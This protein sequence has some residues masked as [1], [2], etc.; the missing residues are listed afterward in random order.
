MSFLHQLFS[1][2]LYHFHEQLEWNW[3]SRFQERYGCLRDEVIAALQKYLDCGLL[4][5]GAARAR[6]Q[7]CN[8]SILIAFS[9]KQRGV[10]P[11]CAT[12]RSL[13]FAEN[14][15][16][17]VLELIKDSK[18]NSAT[19]HQT[20]YLSHSSPIFEQEC[21]GIELVSLCCS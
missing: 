4:A 7:K 13:I 11:S 6:C 1:L 5:Y 3:E 17:N 8:H 20:A 12:K 10:C 16:E 15:H 19:H 21:M 18:I 14:L 9:C 2:D